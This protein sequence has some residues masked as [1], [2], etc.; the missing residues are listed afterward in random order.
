M[1]IKYSNLYSSVTTRATSSGEETSSTSYAYKGPQATKKDESVEISG[2]YD[3]ANG[4]IGATHTSLYLC[5]LPSGGRLMDL[6]IVPSADV[7]SDSDF[8]FNL[9]TVA[10]AT[11]F[12]STNSTG[13]QAVTGFSLPETIATS[14]AGI[15][16]I[17]ASEHLVLTR[18]AG[19]LNETG[20]LYFTA[21]VVAA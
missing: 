2:K 15:A 12:M 7:D 9:G 10:S 11:A 18:V 8:T 14:P 3:L 17:G 21:T 6:K 13:L 1:A 5:A 20:V 19:E 4:A 16:T